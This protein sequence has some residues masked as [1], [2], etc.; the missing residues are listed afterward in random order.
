MTHN[1]SGASSNDGQSWEQVQ[2]ND[3]ITTASA[4]TP[5]NANANVPLAGSGGSATEMV[6]LANEKR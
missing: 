4:N 1:N 5:A 3:E 6:S 2:L